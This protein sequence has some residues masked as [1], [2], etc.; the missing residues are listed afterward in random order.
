MVATQIDA[1]SVKDGR[2]GVK[3]KQVLEAMSRTLRH[4]FVPTHLKSRAYFDS[5]LPI[6]YDQ[7]ISQPYIV[8]YMT[9]SLKL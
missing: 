8:A 3:D 1:R 9:E 5:P 4:E 6:G 2:I 7:T